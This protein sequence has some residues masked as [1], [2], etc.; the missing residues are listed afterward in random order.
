MQWLKFLGSSVVFLIVVG[1]LITRY[2]PDSP[3]GLMVADVW[4]GIGGAWDGIR[5]W[6]DSI[7]DSLEGEPEFQTLDE[8]VD[9]L[10][11]VVEEVVDKE[12][13]MSVA[14]WNSGD[15][16]RCLS[17]AQEVSRDAMKLRQEFADTPAGGD[18]Q[19]VRGS[20]YRREMVEDY[21]TEHGSAEA[22]AYLKQG[23]DLIERTIRACR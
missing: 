11:E 13:V 6:G 18:W 8:E 19:E 16:V 3:P 1:A 10:I 22:V 12:N 9:Y 21:V 23:E 4:D 14:A 5:G 17:V 7:G 15:D 20:Q 2:A